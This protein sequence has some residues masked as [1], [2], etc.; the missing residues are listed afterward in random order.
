MDRFNDETLPADL[1][2]RLEEG[3]IAVDN[4]R[5][6]TVNLEQVNEKLRLSEEMRS[7]FLSN[8]RNEMNNPLAAILGLARQI[9]DRKVDAETA[10][11]M[12][13]TVYREAFDLDFQLRNIFAAAELEAGEV[14][15]SIA[16]LDV[17]AL[18]RQ[19]VADFSHRAEEKRVALQVD[20]GA[21]D[22]GQLLFTTDP[23]KLKIVLANLLANA[24][25][26]TK[27]G[28]RASV[29]VRRDGGTLT[30]AVADQGPGI[31]PADRKKVFDRFVQL[32]TGARKRHRGH[33]LGLSIAK[34][35]AEMLGGSMALSSEEGRGCVFTLSVAELLSA[36]SVDASSSDGNE[37]I[38]EPG[39]GS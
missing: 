10:G 6:M 29:H 23:E 1:Q 2:R 37:F 4:L 3:R 30:I 8:I 13:G 32:D 11:T 19:L 28:T 7:N 22:G 38:F 31:P 26:F 15:F 36:G 5:T 24:V 16:R 27:E 34:A 12:A 14:S 33:G 39:T 21:P 17:A 18:L 20:A 35:Y 25:E 9:A